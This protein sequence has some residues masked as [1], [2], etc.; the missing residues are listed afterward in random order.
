[1]VCALAFGLDLPILLLP[2]GL[3]YWCEILS[4]VLQVAYLRPPTENGCSK[5]SADPPS[6]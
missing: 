2:V 1:M 4:V 5:M 6:F 3:V